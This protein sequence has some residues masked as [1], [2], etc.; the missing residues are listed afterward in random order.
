MATPEETVLLVNIQ[1]TMKR[2][3]NPQ[4]GVQ[5]FL[6]GKKI[7]FYRKD[8]YYKILNGKCILLK[9]SKD[10]SGNF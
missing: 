9:Y 2:K 4:S 5:I 8:F 1:R 10:V 7:P 6:K 3:T